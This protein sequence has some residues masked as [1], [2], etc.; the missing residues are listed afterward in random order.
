M[1][2]IIS[3][4]TALFFAFALNAQ[5]PS[6]TG[7][8]QAVNSN[9]EPLCLVELSELQQKIYGRISRL[10]NLPQES[11][12]DICPG[13]L[14]NQPLVMMQIMERMAYAEGFYKG[15][16]MLDYIT[17]KW[18]NCEM[19]LKDGDPNTLVVRTYTGPLYETRYWRRVSEISMK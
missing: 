13:G 2:K 9:N 7:I 5:T 4:F 16:Q 12:C 18:H 6:V 3:F 8:W 10:M 17:G 19:W 11:T 15:G 14:K 1:T